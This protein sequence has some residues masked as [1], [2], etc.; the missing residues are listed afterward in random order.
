MKKSEKAFNILKEHQLIALLAPKSVENCIIAYEILSP[1]GI[2]LEIAFRTEIA[3]EGIKATLE[4]YPDSLILAGTVMTQKQ[5][6]EAIEAGVA[7]VVSADYIP[8]VVERCV[9]N[10]IMCIPGGLGDAGKQLVQKAELY[11][12]DFESLREKYPYQ[13]IYKLFPAATEKMTFISLSKPWKSAFKGLNIVY[14]GGLSLSNLR[15]IVQWDPDGIICGSALTK[16]IDEPDKM[17]EEASK[18]KEII[19]TDQKRI[20]QQK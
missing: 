16:L 9:E 13:W 4:K 11:Q 14:T 3:L 10:D 15:E 18:W 19:K 7:G 1:M 12:C 2:V 6:I 8:G 5:A 20:E 17:L